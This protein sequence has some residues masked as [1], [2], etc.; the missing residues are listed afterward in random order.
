MPTPRD[1]QSVFDALAALPQ[2]S[3][4]LS[5]IAVKGMLEMLGDTV[6]DDP[7]PEQDAA[8]AIDAHLDAL[9]TRR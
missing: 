8:A 1:R 2:P 7:K 9:A 3:W 6:M 4:V 5:L